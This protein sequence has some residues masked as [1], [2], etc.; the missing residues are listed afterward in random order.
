MSTQPLILNSPHLISS[1]GQR[2]TEIP[3]RWQDSYI[4]LFT[5]KYVAKLTEFC[6]TFSK[7]GYVKEWKEHDGISGTGTLCPEAFMQY[8]N[9]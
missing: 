5:V 8:I 2:H 1:E 9:A 7:L 3:E 6:T 4:S